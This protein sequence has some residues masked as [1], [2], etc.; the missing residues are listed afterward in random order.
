MANSIGKHINSIQVAITISGF[1]FFAGVQVESERQTT[2]RTEYCE[3]RIGSVEAT[4]LQKIEKLTESIINLE[5]AV[6]QLQTQIQYIGS[7][8]KKGG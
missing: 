2:K 8:D 6:V 5:K 4:Q 1:I 7:V 3:K